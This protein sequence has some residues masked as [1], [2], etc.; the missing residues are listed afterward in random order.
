[1]RVLASKAGFETRDS[2][3]GIDIH[4]ENVGGVFDVEEDMNRHIGRADETVHLEV[5]SEDE[6]RQD[7]AVMSDMSPRRNMSGINPGNRMPQRSSVSVN[8]KRPFE[9]VSVKQEEENQL[10]QMPQEIHIDLDR[11]NIQNRDLKKERK[12]FHE[13]Q[14]DAISESV[15]LIKEKSIG[16][17]KMSLKLKLIFWSFFVI[18]I[19][20][21]AGVFAYMFLPKADIHVYPQMISEKVDISARAQTDISTIDVENRII[22]AE[23]VEVVDSLIINKESTGEESA[24]NQKSRGR[25]TIYNEFSEESQ[26]LV[27]TT[28]L[29]SAD[30]KIFRIIKGVIVPGMKKENGNIIPGSIEADVVADQVGDEY[31]IGPSE[32]KIPGFK[33]SSKYEKFYA[34][35]EAK[36]LGG[37]SQGGIVKVVSSDDIKSASQEAQ[38]KLKDVI[39][40]KI[41]SNMKEGYILDEDSIKLEI[42]SE[43][44]FPVENSVAQ[45]FEYQ[46]EMKIY[47]LVFSEN[48][49]ISLIQKTAENK[50]GKS[51]NNFILESIELE[52][53]QI[54]PDFE[55]EFL[56]I[57]VHAT[58]A[59]KK[60]ID[61]D[62]I[63]EGFLGAKVNDLGTIVSGY[64]DIRKVNVVLWPKIL[65]NKIPKNKERV[66]IYI[67]ESND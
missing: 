55:E 58:T 54:T 64:P 25:V 28:R 40:E 41:H 15:A 24:S 11:D 5:E 66:K 32:F 6:R 46:L 30:G 51:E 44:S 38:Q 62:K 42:I 2:L 47:A 26:Q 67:E 53:G 14:V 13:N 52:Y 61:K 35:S 20:L 3:E 59:L 50:I 60:N 36:M 17:K 37:G 4:P 16:N 18:I 43:S 23:A 8:Q 12:V 1:G 48:D 21:I 10:P 29:E 33:S 19:L 7:R 9:N 22:K 49:L 63:L 56:D 45:S 65:V 27:A 34:R 31:N 57:S 39:V